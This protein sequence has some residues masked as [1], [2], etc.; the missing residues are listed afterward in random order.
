LSSSHLQ[1][2][3]DLLKL[4]LGTHNPGKVD[5]LRALL[6][7]LPA[8]LV[9]PSEFGLTLRVA[10]DGATYA[11]NAA[12]K[13]QAYCQA[14]GLTTLADD[15]GLEVQALGGQ[16]GL[17]SARFSPRA[18]ATDADR[19]RLLLDR[20]RDHPT[21][22]QARFVCVVVV[23]TPDGEQRSFR[24]VC[25]G[26]IIPTERGQGGFGYDPIFLIDGLEQTMAELPMD[27]KNR[28]SHRARAVLQALPWLQG[29]SS[30]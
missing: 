27:E 25:P 23:A 14:S 2:E 7:G 30:G 8:A 11:E 29:L 1:E 6:A 15:S 13:A 9:T 19:R 20:L 16:P 21:P 10:E 3:I 24:G 4:L 26:Q 17:H 5:E 22:W 28:L 12:R 18:G